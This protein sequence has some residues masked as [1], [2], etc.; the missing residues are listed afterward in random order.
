MGENLFRDLTAPLILDGATG[1]QLQKRGMPAGSCSEQWLLAHPEAI[2]FQRRYVQ[3][4]SGAVYAP[5]FGANRALLS[6][7]GLG[8]QVDEYN[9]RLVA[10]SR[11]AVGDGVRVGGDISSTGLL[12]GSAGEEEF[13]KLFAI[14]REQAEALEAAGVDFFAVETQLSL[15]EARAAVLAVKEVSRRPI[16]VSF[17]LNGSGR[18]FS[19]GLLPAALLSLEA[20]GIDA[21]GVN[22]VDDAGVLERALTELRPLTELPL[23]V[24]PN[25]G[26]P[27]MVDDRAV[28]DLAPEAMGAMAG[29]FFE[30]GAALFGGCCGSD[31]GH[32]AAMAQALRGKKLSPRPAPAGRWCATEYALLPLE[33]DT[34]ALSLPVDGEFEENAAQAEAEGARLLSVRVDDERQ[35][36]IL[37]SSQ[38]AVHLPLRPRFSDAALRRR[39]LRCYAGLAELR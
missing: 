15:N 35:L 4:G 2:E 10:L 23:L 9:R 21:F 39:F 29:R 26:L 36:R 14:Y 22:C 8:G 20:L 6:R 34:K 18:T 27:T 28:Y 38:G 17:T 31:E 3:S 24:K 37:L 16:L 25:A 33:E 19:G 7:H 13:E 11:Q 32:I 30:L 12:Y 5:T 1:T